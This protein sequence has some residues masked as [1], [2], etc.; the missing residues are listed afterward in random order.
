MAMTS[1]AICRVS[2][3][4][5]ISAKVASNGPDGQMVDIYYSGY[6]LSRGAGWFK[7][8]EIRDSGCTRV[9]SSGLDTKWTV[10]QGPQDSSRILT[11]L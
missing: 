3:V 9:L 11:C 6:T 2:Y 8:S 4:H 7:V 1:R 10:I 5:L